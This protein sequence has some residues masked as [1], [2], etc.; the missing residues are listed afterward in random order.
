VLV[1]ADDAH[2]V[3]WRTSVDALNSTLIRA[4]CAAGVGPDQVAT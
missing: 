2:A 4:A 3:G 1:T